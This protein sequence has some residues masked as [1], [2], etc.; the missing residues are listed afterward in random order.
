MR[1]TTP[2]SMEGLIAVS[3]PDVKP[4]GYLSWF[5]IPDESV[6]LRRL[7]HGLAMYGL[8]P[9]LAPTDTKAIHTFKRAMRE[10]EGR[11]RNGTITETD[12]AQI[13]ETPEFCVYQISRLERDFNERVINYPK[14]L[15]VIFTKAGD[16]AGTIDFEPLGGVPR[17]EVMPIMQAITD[18]YDKNAAKVTGARV[19]AVVRNYIKNSPD[20]QRNQ[21]GLSGENLRGKAGGIY[22]IPARHRGELEALASMLQ[23]VYKG[24]AYLHAVPMADSASEREIVKRHHVANSMD[25]AHEMMTELRGLLSTDR[26]RAPRSDVIAHKWAQFETLRRR[27]G[28]YKEILRDEED[29]IAQNMAI[30]RKQLDQLM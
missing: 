16:A 13:E 22:F 21:D 18:F 30:L 20:E 29:E 12:V 3:D 19:R 5:S 4:L 26:E 8:S 24:K 27:L 25:E 23:E 15:R 6:S 2:K 28:S 11:Q 9:N 7:K 14:A 17:Q 10:Q 1:P